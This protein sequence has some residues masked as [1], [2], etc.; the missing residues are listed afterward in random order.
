MS[1]EIKENTAFEPL[2]LAKYLFCL[3]SAYKH[4]LQQY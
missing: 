2:Y 1:T 3:F 4:L